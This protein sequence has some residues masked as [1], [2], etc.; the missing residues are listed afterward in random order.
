MKYEFIIPRTVP[1]TENIL[2]TTSRLKWLVDMRDPTCT[3]HVNVGDNFLCFIKFM[4]DLH[5]RFIYNDE[6]F[7]WI[8]KLTMQYS[9]TVRMNNKI[10]VYHAY[11]AV[12]RILFPLK[13]LICHIN[14]YKQSKY[15]YMVFSPK[16][17]SLYFETS[18]HLLAAN[19]ALS[20][21]DTFIAIQTLLPALRDYY[22]NAARR[23]NQLRV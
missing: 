8:R 21:L 1:N 13:G 2:A 9:F 7:I 14:Q 15:K 10:H 20:P 18:S 3:D 22:R 5:T 12:A 17:I 11:L 23:D 6:I 19:F 4:L 16:C